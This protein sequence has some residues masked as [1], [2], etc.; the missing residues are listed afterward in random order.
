MAVD[1]IQ[2][3]ITGPFDNSD[4]MWR[5][6]AAYLEMKSWWDRQTGKAHAPNLTRYEQTTAYI[7][8]LTE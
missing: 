5:K 3:Q 2:W 4:T 6:V 1:I 7:L 8:S